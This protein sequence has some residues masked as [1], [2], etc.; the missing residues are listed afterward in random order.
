VDK[1]N[2]LLEQLVK[3]FNKTY[4]NDSKY[5]YSLAP[6]R[7]NLIG[8]HTDYHNG[9]VLPAAIS[10][11]TAAVASPNKEPIFNI[12]SEDFGELFTFSLAKKMEK[13]NKWTCRLEGIIRDTLRDKLN[14]VGANIFIGG[15]LPI[16]KGLSSSASSMA[17]VGAV[18]AYM[19]QIQLD[20]IDFAHKLQK[21]E[22]IYGGV[23]CGLMDQ[24]AVLFGKEEHA[25]L[26]DCSNNN[27]D[28]IKIPEHFA[29]VVF[30][31][32]VKHEL[33]SSEY[34]KRREECSIALE[35]LKNTVP[36][37]LTLRDIKFTDLGKSFTQLDEK[38]Y[39]R[40]YHVLKENERVLE[41][42]KAFKDN[43]KER[44][45]EL[46]LESHLS[47]KYNYEVSCKE[48]DI[49]VENASKINGFIGARMTGGGFGGCTVNI[50]EK[51]AA[52]EFLEQ[53]KQYYHKTT[54]AKYLWGIIANITGGLVC[55]NYNG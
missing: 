13:T 19:N 39:K 36:E 23:I 52:F 49:L 14:P 9:F 16:G 45:S 43:N 29:I 3:K 54:N 40:L 5:F 32:G 4:K 2:L 7:V 1:I 26:I 15:D 8:E 35:I 24:L 12:Y 25:L 46:F 18:I 37:A 51:N 20:K 21:A 22:H 41:T 10:L 42:V 44:I 17:A 31:S 47:L 27:I 53:L 30:D 55:G 33:A 38:L 34:N 48:L 6:G 50:V 28:F 11:Y